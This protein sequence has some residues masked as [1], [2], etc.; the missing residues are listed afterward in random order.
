MGRKPSNRQLNKARND[1][2]IL[3]AFG[4]IDYDLR[5]PLSPYRQKK[6]SK[7]IKEHTHIINSPDEFVK[8]KV[9]KETKNNWEKQGYESSKKYLIIPKQGYDKIHVSKDRMIRSNYEKKEVTYSA[10]GTDLY[11]QLSNVSKR[12]LK[13]HEYITIRIGESAMFHTR[14]D[15]MQ[16]L[17][18]YVNRWHPKDKG[19]IKEELIKQFNV[20]RFFDYEEMREY[21]DQYSGYEEHI[22]KP[23][24]KR[25]KSWIRKKKQKRNLKRN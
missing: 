20:V 21:P 11:N 12:P 18:N 3:K 14:F 6:A 15:N 1:L 7:L 17:L 24:V 9:S 2:K 13:V 10:T 8:R 19:V 5:K 16:D 22:S 25:E 4:F 23:T